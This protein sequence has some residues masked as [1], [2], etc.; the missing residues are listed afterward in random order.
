MMARVSMHERGQENNSEQ[1]SCPTRLNSLLQLHSP[2][3]GCLRWSIPFWLTLIFSFAV[4]HG[5]RPYLSVSIRS[6]ERQF[7]Q[8]GCV[9][10]SISLSRVHRS[11][12]QPFLT[13]FRAHN[14]TAVNP[15]RAHG[16]T[17]RTPM[18]R[19]YIASPPWPSPSA[20]IHGGNDAN[21][22]EGERSFIGA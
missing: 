9:M 22:D 2:Y 15:L 17:R 11:P 13:P 10:S 14:G 4:G 12:M 20:A 6:Q 7:H 19:G 8:T 1:H 5:N 21:G 16:T 3:T 18:T